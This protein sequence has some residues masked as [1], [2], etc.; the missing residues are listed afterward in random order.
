SK[1]SQFD[2]GEGQ[3]LLVLGGYQNDFR[4]GAGVDSFVV[5]GQVIDS[6][7]DDINAED[8]IVFNDIHWQDLWFQR[9]GYDLVLSVNRHIEDKTAQGIF[10]STGS[11]TFSDYF[12][13]NRAKL[14]MRMGDKNA[15]GEREFT[16]LSDN[17]VDTLIQAMSSFAP[18]VG[19]N[20]FIDNLASQEK[21]VMATA[22]ADTT[23]GKVQFA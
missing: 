13:G 3:D 8:M 23:I 16:A 14:V 10:E 19:D 11:V 21:I 12:N 2:G 22:W 1:F 4:G 17:A 15:L 5:S 7:V 20:G 9:S 6:Q 18:T